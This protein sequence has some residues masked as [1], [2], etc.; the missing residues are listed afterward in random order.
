M[1]F[2]DSQD[3]PAADALAP[4]FAECRRNE[5][6]LVDVRSSR[7]DGATVELVTRE[8]TRVSEG[9]MCVPAHV[10]SL[11]CDGERRGIVNWV[12]DSKAVQIA[13]RPGWIRVAPAGARVHSR[14]NPGRRTYLLAFLDPIA[15]DGV[16][17][18]CGLPDDWRLPV[19]SDVRRESLRTV[20]L[21][22]AEEVRAPAMGSA[23]A[24]AALVRQLMVEVLRLAAGGVA[25]GEPVR[26]GLS[27]H[28]QRL[29]LDLIERGLAG[30]LTLDRLAAATGLSTSHFAAAFRQSMGEPPHKYI[31]QRRLERAR[32]L[33]RDGRLSLT[34]VALEAGFGGSSQFAMAFRRATG[35]SPRDWR[36]IAMEAPDDR[37][38]KGEE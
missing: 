19:L 37:S 12:D 35:L 21:A 15:F 10:V 13:M 18:E 26:G 14:W 29:V 9:E 11:L 30:P 33:L 8:A 31:L 22:L 17:A 20:L 25:G 7:W 1:S 34:E 5:A 3:P 28:N 36:R 27:G 2:S 6:P 4:A 32:A 23:I 16:R 38:G 24:G